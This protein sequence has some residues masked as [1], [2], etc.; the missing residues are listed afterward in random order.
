MASSYLAEVLGWIIES[1]VEGP[2][3]ELDPSK[4]PVQGMDPEQQAQLL[5]EKCNQV[6]QHVC[7]CVFHSSCNTF[8]QIIQSLVTTID[9]VPQPIRRLV[10]VFQRSVEVAFPNSKYIVS[11]GYLFLRVIVPFITSPDG[12]GLYH[13]PIE[14]SGRRN[15]LLVGKVMQN[16]ANE[17]SFGAKEV[18]MAVMNPF[19]GDALKRL[20]KYILDLGQMPSVPQKVPATDDRS[21]IEDQMRLHLM[22]LKV[23]THAIAISCCLSSRASPSVICRIWAKCSVAPP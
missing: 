18:Y 11:T 15:L 2:K 16:L 1:L 20:Q 22:L 12:F 13:R 5:G 17:T 4:F 21:T 8:A 6:W 23:R 7:G 3:L 10:S 9:R 19:M 14:Q